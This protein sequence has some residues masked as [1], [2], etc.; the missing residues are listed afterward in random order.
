MSGGKKEGRTVERELAPSFWGDRRAAW[1]RYGHATS[2]GGAAGSGWQQAVRDESAICSQKARR[3]SE[4]AGRSTR[5]KRESFS[6]LAHAMQ[7]GGGR[8]EDGRGRYGP[9]GRKSAHQT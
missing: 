8:K 4:G 1:E 2:G 6:R 5:R 3:K 9:K 7:A